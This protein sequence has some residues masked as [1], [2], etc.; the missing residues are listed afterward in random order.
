MNGMEFIKPDWPWV[1]E[2][3]YTPVVRAGDYLFFAGQT[4]LDEHGTLV[5]EGDLMAQAHQIFSNIRH[6]LSLAG[7][8]MSAVVRL[9]NYFTVPLTQE[10]AE[11]YWEMRKEYFGDHR[12][13]STG[14]QVAGLMTQ[15]RLLEV[16]VIAY[17]PSAGAQSPR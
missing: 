1:A 10:L 3:G 17:V 9:T 5:G 13:A 6:L 4:A 8:D 16:D 14:I 15:E 2:R 12:P 11:S 7:S